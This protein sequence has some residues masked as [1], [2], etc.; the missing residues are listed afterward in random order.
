MPESFHHHLRTQPDFPILPSHQPP[1]QPPAYTQ[2]LS[3]P[4]LNCVLYFWLVHQE[5][6]ISAKVTPQITVESETRSQ[7]IGTG[8]LQN[9]PNNSS[10]KSFFILL[11]FTSFSNSASPCAKPG[12]AQQPSVN[13]VSFLLSHVLDLEE[14]MIFAN[15]NNSCKMQFQSLWQWWK[16]LHCID[17][18]WWWWD[19]SFK[20]LMRQTIIFVLTNIKSVLSCRELCS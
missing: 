14:Y 15:K 11:A 13:T 5:A 2:V 20:G 12:P 10:L 19:W 1:L 18:Q 3:P 7:N 9:F 6:P 8:C 4:K 16:T 17:D